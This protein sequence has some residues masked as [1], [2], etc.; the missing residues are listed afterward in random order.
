MSKVLVFASDILP[1]EGLPT[2]G[3]GLRSWQ[4]IQGLLSH[5]LDVDFRMPAE[6]FLIRNFSE[7]VAK[8]YASIMWTPAD[9]ERIIA[10]S[11]PDVI[12][13]VNPEQNNLVRHPGIPIVTDLHGPR[14]LETTYNDHPDSQRVRAVFISK[15]LAKL[16][17][18]DFITCAG[19]RQR[20]Y[21]LAFLL[22]TGREES[23]IDIAYIPISLSPELPAVEKDVAARRLVYAGGFY[24]WQRATNPLNALEEVL[25]EDKTG[26][27]D[28]YGGSHKVSKQDEINFA[29]CME[30]LQQNERVLFHGYQPRSVLL[31]AF[32]QSL[33]AFEV[34]EK[35]YERELAFTTRT[36]EFL[37]AGLPVIYNNYAEL[38]EHIREYDAGWCVD[39]SDKESVQAAVRD[40]LAN[41][42]KAVEKG[43]NAQ[44]LV[45]ERFT[46]DKTI[47][48]LARF[49]AN[50]KLKSRP[51]NYFRLYPFRRPAMNRL[52]SIHM[53]FCS[54]PFYD[55]I[56]YCLAKAVEK[57]VD[58]LR[59]GDVKS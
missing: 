44:R 57:T 27:L 56:R 5:G 24:P 38:S 35:N 42:Q 18:A 30:R 7:V 4:L 33:A 36:V 48:P 58:R 53:E 39:A 49:C 51:K 13:F 19:W 22:A 14:I 10:E 50:P 32:S 45:R 59:Q 52:S 2:S 28:I 34:M 12:L 9:Q 54:R 47:E 40:V 46:W 17:E 20:F 31:E 21:F 25:R 8:K 15:K 6:R 55:F 37:W 16:A 23:E 3:G 43:A 26:W 41:P 1:L 29:S 11:K